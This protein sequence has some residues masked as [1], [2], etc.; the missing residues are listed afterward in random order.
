MALFDL[1]QRSFLN[2]FR[3]ADFRSEAERKEAVAAIRASK[4]IPFRSMIGVIGS[5]HPSEGS[6]E[7]VRQRMACLE[8]LCEGVQDPTLIPPMMELLETVDAYSREFLERILRNVYIKEHSNLYIERLKSQSV[9]VRRTIQEVLSKV[10]GKIVFEILKDRIKS[11][12]FPSYIEIGN[13]L[14]EIAGHHSIDVLKQIIA[15]KPLNDKIHALDLLSNPRYMKLRK[16]KALEAAFEF[17][18][19]DDPAIRLKVIEIIS[20]HGERHDMPILIG[21]LK[22]EEKR[23]LQAVVEAL[24]RIGNADCIPE[25]VPLLESRHTGIK[26]AVIGTLGMFQDE[27]SIEPLIE[28]LRD[29]NLLIRQKTVEVLGNLGRS[30]NVRIG[31]L[32]VAMMK[33]RDVNVRRSIIEVIRIIG[34]REQIWWKLI[35]YLRDE[36]WW[37]R[38]RVTEVLAEI[39]GPQILDPIVSLL[40]DPYEVVRRYAIE[41]LM[42]L[43]DPRAFEPLTRCLDDPDWWVRERAI[44]ALAQL[45]DDRA[46]PYLNKLLS[47]DRDV[48]FAAVVALQKF[49]HKSSYVPLMQLLDHPLS[50]IRIEVIRALDAI[51]EDRFGDTL[52]VLLNDDD[53]EV[54]NCVLALLPKYNLTPD[55]I[56]RKTYEQIGLALLDQMLI[57]VK[58]KGGE[59]LFIIAD[60]PPYMK[61]R[62]DVARLDDHVFTPEEAR[63]LLMD[64]MSPIQ[65]EQFN[66]MEDIDMSYFIKGEGSRFRVNTYHARSG[67]GAVFRVLADKIMTIEEL[68]LPRPVVDFTRLKQGLVLVT[69]PTGSGKSTTLAAMIDHMNKTRND[70]V[71]TIEDPIEYI[72]QNNRCII[73]Q[74]EVGTHTMSFAN[75]L[76]SALREDPDIILV[77]EMRDYETI[78]IAITAAET[79]HLVLGTLHTVSAAKTID[80]I[81]DVFPGRQQAQVRAMLSE[82]LKGVVSQQLLKRKDTDGRILAMEIMLCNEAIANLIRKEKIFQIPSILTTSYESGMTLM[83]NEL[84]RLVKESMIYPEDAYI[85]SINK[86]EFEQYLTVDETV[87]L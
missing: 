15:E 12:S 33:D 58:D 38:E 64:I 73:N 7:R 55:G 77:G 16:R 17:I 27:R 79:G 9:E 24:G 36:D 2:R 67:M 54:R 60:Q 34:D 28:V 10:G 86:K 42:K 37:V 35:R 30:E 14:V 40:D 62:G 56:R 52:K 5:L 70:H 45:G 25:L 21:L 8:D 72:H 80:R 61:V 3:N 50:E 76:K 26:M 49:G 68:K 13:I 51:G 39:G 41:V 87:I 23:N 53:M 78:S 20:R 43:N 29:K 6:R 22:K 65:I 84:L 69:G 83:D 32:L 71:V 63:R 74:R 44:E 66:L 47:G 48:V 81:I 1:S 4:K 59:D 57:D 11:D 82:S 85:K 31:R 19:N 75:A 18:G 46:V